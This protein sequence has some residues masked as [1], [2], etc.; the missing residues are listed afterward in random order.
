ML[1]AGLGLAVPAANATTHHDECT[2]QGQELCFNNWNNSDIIGLG[3]KGWPNQAFGGENVARCPGTPGGQPV[4]Y[5]TAVSKG[6]QANCPF[7]NVHWDQYY[8]GDTILQ[9]VDNTNNTCLGISPTYVIE[10]MGCNITN[11]PGN[12]GGTGTIWIRT[13][14]FECVNDNEV[15]F[16]NPHQSDVTGSSQFLEAYPPLY[17]NPGGHPYWK[18]EADGGDLYGAC[19]VSQQQ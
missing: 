4:A 6:D 3:V 11:Y 13:N 5:V 18:A 14:N 8:Y 15:L 1:A 16:L 9:M 12:G 10:D 19:W 2:L 7:A 17:G